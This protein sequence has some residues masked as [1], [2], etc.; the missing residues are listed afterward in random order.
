MYS[1]AQPDSFQ[2]PPRPKPFPM[3]EANTFIPAASPLPL[4]PPEAN[5]LF[6]SELHLRS[7]AHPY[8]LP[9]ARDPYIYI[10]GES[11]LDLT[12]FIKKSEN[13][14]A[15]AIFATAK[16][17]PR[18]TPNDS[19]GGSETREFPTLISRHEWCS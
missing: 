17:S 11:T 9:R 10:Y 15:T 3:S 4:S 7:F 16:K 19:S 13:F 6:S 18:E 14:F 2:P 8:P 12:T 1:H 5:L